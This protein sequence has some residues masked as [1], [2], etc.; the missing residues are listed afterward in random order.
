MRMAISSSSFA[1]A[2]A[3]TDIA[4]NGRA[5]HIAPGDRCR[6]HCISTEPERRDVPAINCALEISLTI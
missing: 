4:F 5:D 3:A 6:G 2:F 1:A